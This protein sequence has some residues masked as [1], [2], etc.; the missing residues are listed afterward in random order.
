MP[1]FSFYCKNIKI[2]HKQVWNDEGEKSFYTEELYLKKKRTVSQAERASGTNGTYTS[3]YFKVV[4]NSHWTQFG[5]VFYFQ[6]KDSIF[7]CKIHKHSYFMLVS[8][9]MALRM[10]LENWFL[11]FMKYFRLLC[12]SRMLFG[13]FCHSE[14]ILK[15]NR[16][17][18]PNLFL[19]RRMKPIGWETWCVQMS[20][21]LDWRQ[22]V[23]FVFFFALWSIL[24]PKARMIFIEFKQDH[25]SH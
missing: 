23:T 18:N 25:Y 19:F 22:K 16:F 5:S 8:R 6:G 4:N 1:H 15:C 7:N 2:S 21:E 17:R 12:N 24:Y 11:L 9:S 14:F 10:L 3:S 13:R 20:T